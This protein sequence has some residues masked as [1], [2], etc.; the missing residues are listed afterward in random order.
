MKG[1]GAVEGV[2]GPGRR[3][4]TLGVVLCVTLVGFEAMAVATILPTAARELDGLHAYG[5]AFSSFMLANLVGTMAAG[6]LA[7]RRGPAWPLGAAAVSIALGLGIAAT[8]SSWGVLLLGRALQGLG[9]GAW[10]TVGY[11]LIRIGYPDSLRARMMA[12]VSSSWVLPSLLGPVVAG[13]LASAL[14][15]RWVFAMLLPVVGLALLFLLPAVRALPRRQGTGQDAG[16]GVGRVVA[17]VL[18]AAS[19]TLFL[20]S[21]ELRSLLVLPGV[22]IAAVLAWFAF[23]RVVPRGTLALAAGLPAGLAFRA[24]L[25][26]IFFGA[27]AFVPLGF[28][29]LRG[30]SPTQGGL[31]LTAAS[32]FWV[33]GSWTQARLDADGGAS[34]KPRMIGGLS[35]VVLGIVTLAV[36][37]LTGAPVLISAAGWSISGFGMGLAYPTTSVIVLEKAPEGQEGWISSSLNLMENVGIALGAG[38]AGA[39]FDVGGVLGLQDP[40]RLAITYAVVVAPVGIGLLAAYRVFAGRASPALR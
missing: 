15:W 28:T 6:Q 34:R 27:E 40:L 24:A 32:L 13:A 16:R 2:L 12:I 22:G 19:L 38:L 20:V 31:V 26:F 11:L 4:L 7:D 1:S 33:A 25:S 8:A 3:V 18:L 14:S 39:T 36:V 37:A 35:L 29:L 21:L 23:S 9:G 10:L 5:W 30:F 17:T